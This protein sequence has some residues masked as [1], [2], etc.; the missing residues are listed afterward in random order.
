MLEALFDD[1]APEPVLDEPAGPEG[2]ASSEPQAE[3][4]AAMKSQP[5]KND[6]FMVELAKRKKGNRARRP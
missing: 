2:L 5:E 6:C 4:T 1:A 3:T